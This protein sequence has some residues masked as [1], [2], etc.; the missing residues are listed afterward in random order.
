M[1]LCLTELISIGRLAICLC[2][3]VCVCVCGLLGTADPVDVLVER[4]EKLLPV[5][6]P[7]F[8]GLVIRGCN[9]SLS[10]TRKANT[11]HGGSV[12]PESC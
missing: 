2:V 6:S 5:N 7:H 8:D 1:C 11:P 3:C 12:S 10:I 4:E 9:Q